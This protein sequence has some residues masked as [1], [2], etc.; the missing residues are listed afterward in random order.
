MLSG[1]LGQMALKGPS[2]YKILY[3]SDLILIIQFHDF[4]YHEIKLC[5]HSAFHLPSAICQPVSIQIHHI[6]Q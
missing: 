3:F 1:R 6:S 2:K 5:R 4:D